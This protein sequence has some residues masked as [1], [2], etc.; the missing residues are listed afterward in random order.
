MLN[1]SNDLEYI[2]DLISYFKNNYHYNDNNID[3]N[4]NKTLDLSNGGYDDIP[5]KLDLSSLTTLNL[6][7]NNFK[8][9][10]SDICKLKNLKYLNFS[11][12]MLEYLPHTLNELENLEE[13]YLYKNN[14]K[15][16]PNMY[17][18]K[19]LKKLDISKN[20][21]FEIPFQ[22]TH[23]I[24]LEYISLDIYKYTEK[25]D[26]LYYLKSNCKIE[27]VDININKILIRKLIFLITKNFLK[28]INI[29]IIKKLIKF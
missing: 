23:L 1:K 26:T 24:K 5:K 8:K 28:K 4:D 14:L 7:K 21:F 25:L 11:N 15:K 17:G 27:Q 20:K 29:K 19:K 10:P 6:S 13:L 22:I 18:L 9:I 2:C 12:N 3:N 16:I